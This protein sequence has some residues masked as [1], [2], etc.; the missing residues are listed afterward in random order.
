LERYKF[1]YVIPIAFIV[2]AL[3]IAGV[4][5]LK[6]FVGVPDYDLSVDA[7]INTQY[8]ILVGEVLIQNTGSQPITNIKVDFGEGDVL[9][10]GTLKDK[11][12]IILT[13]P[14]DNSMESVTVSADNNIFVKVSYVEEQFIN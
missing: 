2:I 4:P 5:I 14:P 7:R 10:L 9:D 6:L 8:P 13:P 1:Y 11:H 3:V 12:K